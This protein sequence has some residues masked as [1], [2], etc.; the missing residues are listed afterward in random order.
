MTFIFNKYN[1]N[2]TTLTQNSYEENDI[3]EKRMYIISKIGNYIHSLIFEQH[4]HLI[5]N[6]L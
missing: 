3:N 2:E 6:L 5:N 4:L 1:K